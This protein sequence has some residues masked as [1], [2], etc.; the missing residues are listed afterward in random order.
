MRNGEMVIQH[1]RDS[2]PFLL[3]YED[4]LIIEPFPKKRAKAWDRKND[5]VIVRDEIET[6]RA[7]KEEVSYTVREK[8]DSTVRLTKKYSLKTEPNAKGVSFVTMTGNGDLEFDTKVGLFKSLDMKYTLL[9]SHNNVSITVP[10][11]LS[12]QYVTEEEMARSEEKA[13]LAAAEAR[14][15]SEELAA[16][17]KKEAA[18]R[19]GRETQAF[20][21]SEAPGRAEG[22]PR[23]RYQCSQR[24]RQAARA[25]I[26]RR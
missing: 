14:K 8:K 11:S 6:S 17:Q 12:Y 10:V 1:D 13:R 18:A 3:G 5:V 9:I 20:D 23:C 25:R 16:K 24:G 15:R 21:S 2:L 19:R 22:P 4:M 7:A 26:A